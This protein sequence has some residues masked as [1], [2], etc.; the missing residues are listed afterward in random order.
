MC[1]SRS[2]IQLDHV[3]GNAGAGHAGPKAVQETVAGPMFRRPAEDHVL[4]GL[5][6]QPGEE[7]HHNR[8]VQPVFRYE[9]L[10]GVTRHR[11]MS[12]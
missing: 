11:K 8:H 5:A 3:V 9:R 7:Q 2:D 6:Q 4:R 10:M 1:C 12:K